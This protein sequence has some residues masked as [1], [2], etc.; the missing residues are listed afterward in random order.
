MPSAAVQDAGKYPSSVRLHLDGY[1]V[2]VLMG[3]PAWPLHLWLDS[4]LLPHLPPL[5]R[6]LLE[7]VAAG[8][9]KGKQIRL[10]HCGMVGSVKL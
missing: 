8:V 7:R 10:V 6:F 2:I 5:R 9:W 1:A 3:G 4:G